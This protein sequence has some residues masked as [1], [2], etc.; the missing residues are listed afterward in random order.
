M[1]SGF[2]K[3]ITCGGFF[4]FALSTAAYKYSLFP[5][6]WGV[7]LT[8]ASVLFSS[9]GSVGC[10]ERP[11][12][13]TQDPRFKG[14]PVPSRGWSDDFLRVLAPEVAPPFLS[15][16]T[17]AYTQSFP[18]SFLSHKAGG[19]CIPFS[20]LT[21]TVFSRALSWISEHPSLIDHDFWLV[22]SRW[23][24]SHSFLQSLAV[25]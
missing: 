11:L 23:S 17:T 1:L 3:C 19:F 12:Q 21:N 2:V 20:P 8:A 9:P 6:A 16:W 25:S 7:S 24:C 5:P 22:S 10:D 13:S 4:F 18:S 14:N 15:L